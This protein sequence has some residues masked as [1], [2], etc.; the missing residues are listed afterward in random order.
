MVPT[1]LLI[2]DD[3]A[4]IRLG[5]RHLLEEQPNWKVV[6]EAHDGREAVTKALETKAD[7]A[8]LDVGMSG[9]KRF[10]AAAQIAS[11]VANTRVLILSMHQ[12]E[13]IFRKALAAGARRYVLKSNAPRD[14]VRRSRLSGTIRCSSRRTLQG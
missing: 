8:V 3:H 2:A 9:I 13:T 11:E 12:T 4:L 10:D 7:I 6:A 5:L 1:R 14:L